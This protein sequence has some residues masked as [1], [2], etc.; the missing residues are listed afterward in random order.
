MKDS[1]VE[2][3]QI[4]TQNITRHPISW[5]PATQRPTQELVHS[6]HTA[7]H[8]ALDTC[9]DHPDER[10]SFDVVPLSS[11]PLSGEGEEGEKGK[12]VVPMV[13]DM[14]RRGVGSLGLS[15]STTSTPTTTNSSP[16][17]V[18]PLPTSPPKYLKEEMTAKLFLFSASP[19]ATDGKKVFTKEWIDEAL[20]ALEKATGLREVDRFV[21]KLDGIDWEWDWEEGKRDLKECVVDWD[22]V[23]DVWEVRSLF[24]NLLRVG[25]NNDLT[26]AYLQE[27]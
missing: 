15:S 21:L 18:S 8:F 1:K 23:L 16:G 19:S 13:G 24:S 6:V 17:T 11:S 20:D 27:R 3:V 25:A 5:D 22:N 26:L 10:L 14:K 7:L 12:L 9:L 4:Y 2:Q